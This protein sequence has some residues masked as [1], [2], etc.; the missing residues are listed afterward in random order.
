MVASPVVAPDDLDQDL[1]E[2]DKNA[3]VRRCP[4]VS[5]LPIEDAAHGALRV[6]GLVHAVRRMKRPT[7]RI[8]PKASLC[9]AVSGGDGKR[10][11]ALG[12][13]NEE[14]AGWRACV[15]RGAGGE[16]KRQKL[17]VEIQ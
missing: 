14:L 12:T 9:A 15:A 5:S 13:S 2:V 11:G 10:G 16:T 8:L 7:G 3:P 17:M 6:H 4:P 1:G